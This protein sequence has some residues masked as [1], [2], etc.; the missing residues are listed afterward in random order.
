MVG[1]QGA[2]TVNG[3]RVSQLITMRRNGPRDEPHGQAVLVLHWL[4]R[5]V[6]GL[7]DAGESAAL[8]GTHGV[9]RQQG[10]QDGLHHHHGD[11]FAHAGAGPTAEGLE[12]ATGHLSDSGG[13][14]T[15]ARWCLW[16]HVSI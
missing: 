2:E 15:S 7:L 4:L 14:Q 9:L 6:V 3:S 11:V 12:E 10:D 1:G 16:K 5:Q 8:A 13:G